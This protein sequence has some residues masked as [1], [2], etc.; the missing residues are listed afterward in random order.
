MEANGQRETIDLLTKLLRFL[1]LDMESQERID[2]ALTGFGLS[3]EQEK[4]KK[5]KDKTESTKEAASASV[6]LVAKDQRRLKCIFCKLNHEVIS[7]NC[8]SA[9]KL[10]LN[11]RKDIVKKEGCCFNCLKRGHIS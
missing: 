8:E 4:M 11:E 2:M 10:T 1:Q 3:T 7:L 5:L 6:L 9:R